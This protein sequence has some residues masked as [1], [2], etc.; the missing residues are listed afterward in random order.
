MIC[1]GGCCD[2]KKKT[3]DGKKWRF[4]ARHGDEERKVHGL[5]RSFQGSKNKKLDD[6]R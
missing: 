5:G 1:A 3:T 4:R 6:F 2:A